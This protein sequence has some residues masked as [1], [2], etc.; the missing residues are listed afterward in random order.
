[1]VQNSVIIR[2]ATA[3]LLIDL[4]TAWNLVACLRFVVT[5]VVASA[6]S[7]FDLGNH[8]NSTPVAN[9]RFVDRH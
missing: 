7:T 4:T 8:E 5:I 2:L 1:M 3:R 6:P 9:L